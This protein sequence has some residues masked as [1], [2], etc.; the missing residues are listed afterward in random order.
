MYT[1]QLRNYNPL[2]SEVS[3]LSRYNPNY[4]TAPIYEAAQKWRD[5]ALEAGQSVFTDNK[6]LWTQPLLDELVQHYVQ[7]LVPSRGDFL[8]K[9]KEQLAEGSDS[10]RQ[11]MAEILW[12][13]LLFPSP[14]NMGAATKREIVTE[15]WSWSGEKLDPTH[16]LLEDAVL[17]DIDSAG[18]YNQNRWHELPLFIN[19][20]RDFRKRDASEQERIASDPWEFSGWLSG[21]PEEGARQLIHI[22]PHLLFPDTFERISSGSDKRLILTCFID[23]SEKEIQKWSTVKIDRALLDLRRR[24]EDEHGTDI[25]FY[26]DE[27]KAQWKTQTKSWLLSWNPDNWTWDTLTADHDW[28]CSSHKP[29]EGDRVF[30]VRTRIPP[31]GIVAVGKV[32]RAPHE[33]FLGVAFDSVRDATADEIVHLEDLQSRELGQEWNPRSSGIEIKAEAAKTLERLWKALPPIKTD[34]TTPEGGA[35]SGNAPPKNVA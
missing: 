5:T 15:T 2:Q 30:V 35:G 19:A 12:L 21:F 27:F 31:K 10:C 1:G 22:L 4:P 3:I 7:N 6:K 20:L 33:G 25:D 13:L 11:L 23:T 16:P 14:S 29:I 32:T 26:Q 18:R 24:L 8:P 9:L 34:A 17:G 28:R